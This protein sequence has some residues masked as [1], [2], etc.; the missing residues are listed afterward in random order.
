MVQKNR[1]RAAFERD[2]VRQ[3]AFLAVEQI[4][5]R[6]AARRVGFHLGPAL[7]G[8]QGT[9]LRVRS[10]G[11]A[12][13]FGFAAQWAAVGEAGLIRLQLELFRAEDADFDRKRHALMVT[14]SLRFKKRLS[15]LK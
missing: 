5:N 6:L 1:L 4:A 9:A 3:S 12:G 11:G 10:S 14:K 13:R 15:V 8:A 7:F 2:S